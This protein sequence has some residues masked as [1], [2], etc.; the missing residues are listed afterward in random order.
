MFEVT[1]FFRQKSTKS[2]H[3]LKAMAYCQQ[4]LQYLRMEMIVSCLE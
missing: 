4:V 1:L 3:L 2:E